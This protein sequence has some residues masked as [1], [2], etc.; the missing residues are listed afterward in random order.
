MFKRIIQPRVAVFEV[1]EGVNE[2]LDWQWLEPMPSIY[3]AYQ[4]DFLGKRAAQGCTVRP[5]LF[6]LGASTFN[7]SIF[8]LTFQHL[9]VH[10]Y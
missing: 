10:Y 6:A 9:N 1:V 7:E 5:A 8:S 3:H 4:P 2:N